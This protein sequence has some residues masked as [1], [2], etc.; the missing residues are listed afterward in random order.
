MLRETSGASSVRSRCTI[1]IG[2][3]TAEMKRQHDFIDLI[4]SNLAAEL[5]IS[6]TVKLAK[7]M[8]LERTEGKVKRVL[9]LRKF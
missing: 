2:T 4:R 6:V 3:P 8:T 7:K 9:D 1:A 5:S